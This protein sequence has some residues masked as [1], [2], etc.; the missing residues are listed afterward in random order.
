M[1]HG[2]WAF[3]QGLTSDYTPS[4]DAL[5]GTHMRQNPEHA[6]TCLPRAL[7]TQVC[8]AIGV[9]GMSPAQDSPSKRPAV[10]RPTSWLAVGPL[11]LWLPTHAAEE[12]AKRIQ[13]HDLLG[14]VG[15]VGPALWPTAGDQVAWPGG[16][17]CSW[18]V[19]D[20]P[21]AGL[22][23]DATTEEGRAACYVFCS[24]LEFDRFS[25]WRVVV[26]GPE[27]VQLH[28]NGTAVKLEAKGKDDERHRRASVSGTRGKHAL[29]VT[30]LVRHGKESD[31]KPLRV[32]LELE[33]PAK[34]EPASIARTST[35]PARDLN[36][37]D[38]L[39]T[40]AI[41]SA[42]IAPDGEL[43]AVQWRRPEVPAK[44]G[45]TWT[46]VRQVDSGEVV[47]STHG[48]GAY[49]SWQ[50]GPRAGTYAYVTRQEGKA[51]LWV[52]EIGSGE[53][54]ALLRDVEDFGSFQFAPDGRSVFFTLIEKEKKDEVGVDRMRGLPDRWP[55]FRNRSWIHE[56]AIPEAPFGCA[57]SRRLTAGALATSLEDVHPEGTHLLFSRTRYE[58]QRFPFSQVE[59]LELDLVTMQSRLL[60]TGSFFGTAQ[61][62]PDGQRIAITGGPS[63]FGGLGSHVPEGRVANDYDGQVY[64]FTRDGGAVDAITKAFDP[65]VQQVHWSRADGK[66]YVR[67]EDGTHV[68]VFRWNEGDGSFSGLELPPETV[69]GMTL[70][71]DS[72]R[73]V[74]VGSSAVE[75]PRL[76]VANLE[77]GATA[78]ILVD[79]NERAFRHVELGH[80]EDFDVEVRP[81]ET[82]VGR[83]H[84]PAHF[85]PAKRH[86]AI[87]YYYGGTSPVGRSF[88]G[89]YPKNFWCARGYVVYV[90]QPS[91][92]T[93]FG[94]EFSSRHV[95]DWGQTVVTEIDTATK[96]FLEA[97][98]YVDPQRVGC[99]GASYG[100]FTTMLLIS[101]TQ[102]FAAAIS[103]AGISSIASYWGE[104]FWGYLYSAV[105]TAESYPWNRPD[106]YVKQ[107]ALYR[108]DQIRTPLLL[109]HGT[110][111]TNV[112]V[113]ESEQMY[114]ALRVL[115]RDVEF[116][117]VKGEDH[118][119]LAYEKRLRWSET[120]VAYFDWKLKGERE[121]WDELFSNAR[122]SSS[123]E[124]GK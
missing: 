94:Q 55:T 71:D 109:L 35:D 51:T 30:A 9:V 6:R 120:I 122:S 28:W 38:L 108:A 69:S 8:F 110:A 101:H 45:Q 2:E 33:Q 16:E 93:G 67:A 81:G 26:E 22:S 59:L 57:A 79:P 21:E 5:P 118:H 3:A 76:Y 53:P 107:S 75:P 10:I 17:A 97:H 20:V 56:V 100:G 88:G 95:N 114:T 80:V 60:F 74:F 64:V 32:T 63:T 77:E 50:W 43:V 12:D 24:Y 113:G 112:P 19:F 39:D 92:A 29:F 85:D 86:P 15:L 90:L 121:H 98:P 72:P 11:D 25:R 70:A 91:G 40:K 105:A 89:R 49:S 66:L 52:S 36:L 27:H 13:F 68:R 23:L 119:I 106:L 116:V 124:E 61:Y 82:I 34:L 84:F 117:K 41:T 96:A 58:D 31:A 102:R 48:R 123:E 46:E 83:V 14:S 42:S 47:F 44:H 78:R 37:K 103:H 54:T 99:I 111:D 4:L 65:S 1:W 7:L 18:Q 104:G 115:G 73:V 87:V 62:A